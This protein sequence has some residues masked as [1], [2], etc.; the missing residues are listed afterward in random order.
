MFALAL[1]G[2]FEHFHSPLFCPKC[3][4]RLFAFLGVSFFLSSKLL[5]LPV[6]I[7]KESLNE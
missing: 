5:V 6:L 7:S 1:K 2:L 3:F 4:V